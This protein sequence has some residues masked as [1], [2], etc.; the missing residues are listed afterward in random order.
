[1]SG[2]VSPLI[3][4]TSCA[5]ERA[6]AVPVDRVT[7]LLDFF[8]PARRILHNSV[9]ISKNAR[10]K[11]PNLQNKPSRD[12]GFLYDLINSVLKNAYS[13]NSTSDQVLVESC[14]CRRR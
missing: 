3:I 4:G 12:I 1:L 9:A 14:Y 7:I 13:S 5:Q 2:G 10:Q 11:I 6:M 8:Q